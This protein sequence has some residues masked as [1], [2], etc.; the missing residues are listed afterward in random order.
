MKRLSVFA[1]LFFE[2]FNSLA[3]SYSGPESVVFDYA[4]DRYLISNNGA[5]QIL[6]RAANGTL[7]V[8]TASISSGP[9]GLEIVGD[10]LYACDGS[11]LKLFSLSSGAP[12]G[13]INL[14]GSFLNGI[15]TDGTQ[16]IYVTDFTQKK[17]FKVNVQDRSF[18]TFISGLAKTPNGIIFDGPNQRIIWVTWGSGAPIMQ[19]SLADSIPVQLAATSLGNCDGIDADALGNYYVSAW[20]ANGI[21]R[22]NNTF[23]G[24][25]V[26]VVSGLSSPADIYYNKQSDTLVSPN[27]GNNTVTF[28]YMGSGMN[29]FSNP[30]WTLKIYPNPVTNN[31]KL[32]SQTVMNAIVTITNVQGEVLGEYKWTGNELV[33]NNLSGYAGLLFLHVSSDQGHRVKKI[34]VL[35]QDR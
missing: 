18:T 35:R 9:H 3:Q 15:T 6:S 20:S 22:F 34:L 14:G 7:S 8:F 5:N 17:I 12:L 16:Y 4:N 30:D 27:A 23:S 31:L 2:V 29:I 24:L 21:F 1:M 28:H 10:T 33:I 32:E 26:Q 13:T 25:P 19:A 11:G